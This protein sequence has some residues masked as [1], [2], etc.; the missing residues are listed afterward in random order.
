[1]I[2]G[3]CCSTSVDNYMY[4]KQFEL[5]DLFDFQR[6]VCIRNNQHITDIVVSK[7]QIFVNKLFK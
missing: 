2:S 1:M 5:K 4:L 6:K 7:L 3:D